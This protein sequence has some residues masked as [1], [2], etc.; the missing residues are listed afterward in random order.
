[1]SEQQ[2]NERRP[3]ALSEERNFQLEGIYTRKPMVSL[4]P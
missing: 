2:Q 3:V 1:M 4:N